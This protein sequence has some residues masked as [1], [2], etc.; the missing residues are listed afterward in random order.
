MAAQDVST[1]TYDPSEVGAIVGHRAYAHPVKLVASTTFVKGEI[2][3]L[4]TANVATLTYSRYTQG[5]SDGT[6][7]AECILRRACV[8]D[9]SGNITVG[10]AGTVAEYGQTEPST[11]AWFGGVFRKTDLTGTSTH[12][13][14]AAGVAA[15]GGKLQRNG[16][17][18]SF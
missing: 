1:A 18:L 15:M 8:T 10:P 5:A 2:L 3:A 7:N 16:A 12:A 6:Q 9:A 17:E 4:A 11:S 14:D 13:L